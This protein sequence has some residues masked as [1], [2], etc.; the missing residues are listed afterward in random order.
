MSSVQFL[1]KVTYETTNRS[2]PLCSFFPL[3][4]LYLMRW[5]TCFCQHG[6]LRS[7]GDCHG[8]RVPCWS[9]GLEWLFS[10]ERCMECPHI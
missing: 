5:S 8:Y 9:A 6:D 1:S 10:A 3:I 4:C 7:G 2:G